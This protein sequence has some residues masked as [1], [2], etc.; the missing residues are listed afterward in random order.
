MLGYRLNVIHIDVAGERAH[1]GRTLPL[2]RI[3]VQLY[4]LKSLFV[5]FFDKS[6]NRTNARTAEL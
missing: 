3:A 5:L 2:A 4:A 6:W 1:R